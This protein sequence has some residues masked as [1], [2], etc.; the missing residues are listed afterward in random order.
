MTAALGKGIRWQR[1]EKGENGLGGGQIWREKGWTVWKAP[2]VG[3]GCGG[4][5]WLQVGLPVAH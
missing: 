2:T 5:V 3:V 4:R 1:G